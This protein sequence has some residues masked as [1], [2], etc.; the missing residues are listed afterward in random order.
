MNNDPDT[1]EVY[2]FASFA[3]Y[4]GNPKKVGALGA[5]ESTINVRDVP[6]MLVVPAR[7]V[8]LMT[9]EYE[10]SVRCLNA[11]DEVGI[12]YMIPLCEESH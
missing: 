3:I 5:M 7:V 1:L 11:R 10:P 2:R 12:E 9:N 8:L 4:P 6:D